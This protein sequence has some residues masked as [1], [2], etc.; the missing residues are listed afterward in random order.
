M[1]VEHHLALDRGARSG[2]DQTDQRAHQ[3]RFTRARFAHDAKRAAGLKVEVDAIDRAHQA[4]RRGEGNARA[5]HAEQGL[6]HSAERRG[7]TKLRTRSPRKFSDSTVM[8]M[9]MAGMKAMCG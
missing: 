3:H 2:A 6:V 5:A 1:A 7:S 4:A 9:T 8:N